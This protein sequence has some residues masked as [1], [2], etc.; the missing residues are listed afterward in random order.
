MMPCVGGTTCCDDGCGIAEEEAEAEAV[1][2]TG[3]G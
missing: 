2:D 1:E 3:G